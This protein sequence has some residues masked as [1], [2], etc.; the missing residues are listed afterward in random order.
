MAPVPCFRSGTLIRTARGDVAVENLRVGDIVVT[1][2]GKERP[3]TWQGHVDVDCRTE[4]DRRLA[5]PIRIAAHAYGPSKP[6]RDLYVSPYHRILVGDR[7]VVAVELI[8]GATIAQ[9]EMDTVTY[10]HVEL[11][12]HDVLLANNLPAESYEEIGDSRRLFIEAAAL[13][14]AA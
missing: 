13:E 10:W 7:L 4:T 11:A 9:V 12:S 6:D 8:N 1:A 2:Y 3:V 5:W 14:P